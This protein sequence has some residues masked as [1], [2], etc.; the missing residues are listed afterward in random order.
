MGGK[1]GNKY[2]GTMGVTGCFSF[3]PTKNLGAIG[4]GGMIITHNDEVA[5]RLRRYRDHG[6]D[7]SGLFQ[8][9]GYNSRLD[10]IQAAILK[11]KLEELEE[12]IADRI[13]NARFYGELLGEADIVLPEFYERGEHTY[14]CYTIQADDRDGLRQ[15]LSEQEIGTAIYYDRPL[16]LQ[17]CLEYLG[18]KE[19]SFPV[20]ELLASRVLSLPIFPGLKMKDLESVALSIHE[21]L[22]TQSV[23]EE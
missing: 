23:T 4:D 1:I 5:G 9:I 14:N 22:A 15:F 16:H 17:P 12:S 10:S 18:Y 21:Y 11:V 19:G 13:E 3:Y 20:A 6:K 2:L 7:S 8:D